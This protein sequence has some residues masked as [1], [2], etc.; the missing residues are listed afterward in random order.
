MSVRAVGREQSERAAARFLSRHD[1]AKVPVDPY[2]LAQLEGIT[3]L[4]EHLPRDTSS[5]L[6]R[7]PSGVKVICV[8]ASHSETRK[9]FSVAHE[10]GHA[11]LHFD[12][13]PPAVSEAAVSRPLEVLFRD[14]AAAAGTDQVEIDANTFAAAVLMPTGLAINHFRAKLS[15][16]PLASTERVIK[17]L[18]TTF[19]V[20]QQAMSYR[21]VNLGLVDPA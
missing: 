7:E 10:L 19:D 1:V 6:L 17:E 20:S 3:V 12:A 4:F 18:A 16:T 8:N 5:L 14:G 21:L 2:E 9:R 11:T 15:E 13:R